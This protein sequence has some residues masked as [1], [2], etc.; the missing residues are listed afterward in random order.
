MAGLYVYPF[1]GRKPMVYTYADLQKLKT[2]VG[3]P[4]WC[5]DA[6]VFPF[7]AKVPPQ[8]CCHPLIV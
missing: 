4:D 5:Q 1:S 3:T 6:A 8:A 2:I 7:P